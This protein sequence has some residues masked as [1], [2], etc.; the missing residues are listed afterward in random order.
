MGTVSSRLDGFDFGDRGWEPVTTKS[1]GRSGGAVVLPWV[2][3]PRGDLE[4]TGDGVVVRWLRDL[5]LSGAGRCS[6]WV[7]RGCWE[8]T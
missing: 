4:I 8:G 5:V 1:P 2:V 7:P 3:F 6:L